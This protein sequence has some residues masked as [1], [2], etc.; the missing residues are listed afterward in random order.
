MN[1][2]DKIICINDYYNIDNVHPEKGLSVGGI[3]EIMTIN[4]PIGS[5]VWIIDNHGT[6]NFYH[7]DNFISLSDIKGLR[8]YKLKKLNDAQI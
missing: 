4:D 7:K 5:Y 1:Y 3:Y 8:K 6:V 2:H